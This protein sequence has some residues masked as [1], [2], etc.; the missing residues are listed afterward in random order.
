MTSYQYIIDL[1]TAILGNSKAIQ[2]RF[3]VAHR[4]GMQD[5]NFDQLGE[6]ITQ[7]VPIKTA[8]YPLA[9]MPSPHSRVTYRGRQDGWE[10]FRIIL[11]FCKTSYTD[12]QNKVQT[13]NV[14]TK[15]SLHTIPQDWHDMKRCANNFIRALMAV[16]D[17]QKASTF[18]LP[19][20]EVLHVP[21]SI[22]GADNVSGVKSD[23]DFDL[24]TGCDPIEDYINDEYPTNLELEL[25][26]HPEHAL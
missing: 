9:I 7:T 17:A 23:F 1:F 16:Q 5:I 20:N 19:S 12:S 26:S 11:F 6:V 4:Y 10:R 3:H 13:P 18:R 15:T 25:D 2:G 21:F 8:K 24:F 22:I 14:K